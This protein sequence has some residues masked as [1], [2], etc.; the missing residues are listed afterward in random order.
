MSIYKS[1]RNKR[2]KCMV[3]M[4]FLDELE[5]YM[6]SCP[7]DWRLQI[8]DQLCDIIL[9]SLREQELTIKAKLGLWLLDR[10]G[11]KFKDVD[12]MFQATSIANPHFDVVFGRTPEDIEGYIYWYMGY[13]DE[14]DE[15]GSPE[16]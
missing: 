13:D 2:V 9:E 5:Q 11:W 6:M 15:D 16:E 10:S 12:R 7:D 4:P 14:D 3:N 1:F 8:H